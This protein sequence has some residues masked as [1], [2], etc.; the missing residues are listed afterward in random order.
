MEARMRMLRMYL[1]LNFVLML[2]V[3]RSSFGTT[4]VGGTAMGFADFDERHFW[5]LT[6]RMPS[7]FAISQADAD[8]AEI[9]DAPVTPGES[10]SRGLVDLL[11]GAALPVSD[12]D[13]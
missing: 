9:E 6:P 11:P 10:S 3:P 7:T 2:F 8:D 12:F 4:R 5:G 13:L 1:F